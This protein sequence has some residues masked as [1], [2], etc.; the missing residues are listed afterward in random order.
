MERKRKD[1]KQAGK[2]IS[3]PWSRL[4]KST[5]PIS[6]C[7]SC[8]RSRFNGQMPNVPPRPWRKKSVALF[9]TRFQL[10]LAGLQQGRKGTGGKEKEEAAQLAAGTEESR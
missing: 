1:V 4:D 6:N 8:S 2:Q 5:V 9:K 3:L 7:R 10:Q